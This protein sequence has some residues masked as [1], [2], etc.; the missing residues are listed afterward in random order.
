ML[1]RL[2]LHDRSQF[3]VQICLLRSAALDT[4]LGVTYGAM[5]PADEDNEFWRIMQFLMPFYT[6]IPGTSSMGSA[7]IWVPLNDELTMIWEPSWSLTGTPLAEADRTGRA[8]RVPAAG[9]LPET[10]QPLSRWVFAD[11]PALYGH[12]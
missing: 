6:S 10:S 11:N 12:G 7:K 3:G 5:R 4:D 2:P 9:F 1:Q 8:G